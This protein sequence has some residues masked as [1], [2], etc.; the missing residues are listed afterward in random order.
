MTLFSGGFAA[1]GL[2]ICALW[3]YGAFDHGRI[4]W[5]AKLRALRNILGA[6]LVLGIG[7]T[8]YLHDE[9]DNRAVIAANVEALGD[10]AVWWGES[11]PEA[12]EAGSKPVVTA[13]SH[14]PDTWYFQY[15]DDGEQHT[16]IYVGGSWVVI[17]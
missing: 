7:L 3:L 16:V 6:L 5:E 14:R 4:R 13:F 17:Q 9:I 11:N 15:E 12:K 2:V 8:P 10:F 1:V